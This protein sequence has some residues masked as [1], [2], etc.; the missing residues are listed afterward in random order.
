[1]AALQAS[2]LF[3]PLPCRITMEH[4]HGPQLLQFA[5]LPERQH[6]P[7]SRSGFRSA[8]QQVARIAELR[9]VHDAFAWFRSHARELEDLQLEVTSIPAPPWGEA[10]RS[11]WLAR[12]LH[13]DLACPTCIATS[14]ATSSAFGRAPIPRRRFIA[15]SAHIDTVFPAGTPI[16]RAARRRQALWPRHLR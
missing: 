6:P 13:R 3:S 2:F 10:A 4:P 12:A 7:V 14:W 9:R 5:C 8:Q 15:L 16:A 11:E 1:M